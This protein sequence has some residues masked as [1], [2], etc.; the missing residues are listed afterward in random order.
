VTLVLGLFWRQENW[1]VLLDRDGVVN[2]PE[3]I[4]NAM[5]APVRPYG[6]R[7]MIWYQGERN[8]KNIPQ[9]AHY[10]NQLAVMIGHFRE[11]WH[12]QSNG[13][14]AR[15]FPF[16]FTQLPSW[17]PPQRD[18]VEGV[19]A[20]W[21]VSRESMR[22]AEE[23][24]P[25]TA[26]AVTIDTGDEVELHPKNKKPIGIRHAL[27]AL[28]NTY[29]RSIVGTGPR[30][31][32]QTI[33]GGEITLVFESSGRGLMTGK[34]GNL[35]A[36]A[37]SGED[38]KWYWAQG[39][40]QGDKV[41][42]H[43]DEVPSPVAVRYAWAMNPSGRNL[44]YNREGLPASPFRTDE[45]PLFD[46]EAE[47]VEVNKPKKPE[48]YVSTDWER[49]PM[50]A[51]SEHI[52]NTSKEPSANAAAPMLADGTA[53]E[54]VDLNAEDASF[55]LESKLPYLD[56]P[57]L[58]PGPN[59]LNDG[60]PVARLTRAHGDRRAILNFAREIA[61][62]KHG[63]IDSFLL[64]KDGKLLYESYF[65]RGRSNF[66][67]YQMSIT[68]SY[69][70]MALGRAIQLGHFTME[71]L[72]RPVV[73]FLGE[74]DTSR[75]VDGANDITL[76]EAMNMHSGIRID[77]AAAKE[78]RKDPSKLIGQGQ[79]QAYLENSAPIP[80]APRDYKYQGS[81]PSMIMQVIEAVVP[82]TARSFIEEELL[83]QMGITDYAWQTD[84]SGLPKAAAGSSFRSRD[85]LKWG[86]L[87]MDEGKWKDEQLIPAEFVT[88]A[89]DRLYTNLQ[90]TSYG[91]FW[92]RHD[93]EVGDRKI[94][95]ISGRGAGGQFILMF[96]KLKLISVI[97]AH[98]KGMGE[99]LKVFPDKVLS[100][101]ISE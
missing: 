60:I 94:D 30:L 16:Q 72:D 71:D 40:I 14:V 93:M 10:R 45:W 56:E 99:T 98:N 43:S 86:M 78:L 37:I 23:E 62:G 84:T 28:E 70:A 5:I 29:R 88:Q 83:G 79:V 90:N 82:G 74:L 48:G 92:W 55:S 9:A 89:T 19:N 11:T 58:N 15:D 68:K 33:S 80:A 24:I 49:P 42:L 7:G 54:V 8:A 38:Q 87:L 75:L 85:M 20:P 35:D 46:P 27:L 3:N 91:F 66:P 36:F 6:I 77:E 13:H 81:D 65:R 57:F 32:E 67:H 76:A 31:K 53:P 100:A 96:P 22:L 63:E 25:N 34:D 101:L 44:L 1:C 4:Y 69:T 17:N 41:V 51:V 39:E 52:V 21:A 95:C 64:M 12:A 26:M 61:S 59:Q 97:T 50:T 2:R 47:L 73:S 18:P